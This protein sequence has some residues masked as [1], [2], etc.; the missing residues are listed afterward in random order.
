MYVC[1]C[2]VGGHSIKTI[3]LDSRP[4]GLSHRALLHWL[5]GG[6]LRGWL[7]V[8]A[9]HLFISILAIIRHIRSV[10][11]YKKEQSWWKWWLA[12]RKKVKI[13]FEINPFCCFCLADYAEELRFYLIHMTEVREQNCV[14]AEEKKRERK[15]EKA[16][17]MWTAYFV[18]EPEG[19]SNLVEITLQG[20]H[21]DYQRALMKMSFLCVSV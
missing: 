20:R 4:R 19:Q 10:F 9:L 17:P 16:G 21:R 14:C 7:K 2:V 15:K 5:M 1:M 6:C 12:G 13:E 3:Y 18:C 8:K 11:V